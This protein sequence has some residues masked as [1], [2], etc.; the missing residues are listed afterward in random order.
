M[1][2]WLGRTKRRRFLWG[3]FVVFALAWIGARLYLRS[4]RVA[5]LAAERLSAKFD[6]NVEIGAGDIGIIDDD[7]CLNSICVQDKESSL[8]T[9]E[10]LNVDVSALGLLFGAEPTRITLRGVHLH[11]RFDKEG[12]LLSPL[13]KVQG[14]GEPLPRVVIASGQVTLDQEGRAPFTLVGINGELS[15]D[16][17]DG[18]FT[19]TL[20]D[21]HWGTWQLTG[22]FS[23]AEPSGWLGLANATSEITPERLEKIPFIP[24]AIWQ[25][26][27]VEGTIPLEVKLYFAAKS[28]KVRYHVTFER[29]RLTLPARHKARPDL[30]L[31]SA[32]AV[33][34][35]DDD[36]LSL[37]GTV[38]DPYWGNWSVHA[39]LT[40]STG[41]ITLDVQTK[42]AL[43]TPA[44]LRALPWVPPTIWEQVRAEG[45]TPVHVMVSLVTREPGVRYRV[46]LQP[47]DT[48][49]WVK[50]IDLE[51]EHAG[52]RVEVEDGVVRLQGVRGKTAGGTLLTD[53]NFDFRGVGSKLK[54]DVD[55][56]GLSLR[57]LPAAWKLPSQIDGKLSGKADLQVSVRDGK[58]ETRGDGKGVIDDPRLAGFRIQTPIPLR[59]QAMGPRL[60][61]SSPSPLI[62]KLIQA[63]TPALSAAPRSIA[64]W[65]WLASGPQ[66]VG[67]ITD[68]LSDEAART[69]SGL[70]R[71][72][73][74]PKL[75]QG[76]TY[77]EANLSLDKVDLA[78]LIQRLGLDMPAPLTGTL[79]VNLLLAIPIDAPRDLKAYRLKGTAL[80]A[81]LAVDKMEFTEVQVAVDYA[82]GLLRLDDLAG[83]LAGSE[84]NGG[85]LT[86][87]A[88]LQLAPR[89]EMQADLNLKDID[90][91]AL[92]K[93]FPELPLRLAGK[94]TATALAR[95]DPR[96][97]NGKS[98]VSAEVSVKEGHL[99]IHGVPTSRLKG[100]L[101]FEGGES[102]YR[103]E[104]ES[105]GGR[106]E[107]DAKLPGDT[108]EV[109]IGTAN[110]A[111]ATAEA[112]GLF[113]FERVRL[114]QVW[115]ILGQP[116]RLRSLEGVASLELPLRFAANGQP[117]GVGKFRILD[118]R[119]AD[120][121]L[122]D[123][124][125]GEIRLTPDAV[126][127][128]DV[129]ADLAGGLLRLQVLY[130]HH[131]PLRSNFNLSLTRAEASKLLLAIP[132]LGDLI[133]GAV[134]IRIRGTLGAEWRGGGALAMSRGKVLNVEITDWRVPFEFS[135]APGRGFGELTIRDSGAH[136][137]GGRA[138]LRTQVNW[139]G[140]GL[141]IDGT[142]T[143]I[144][145]GMRSLVGLV[146]DV[147]SYAQGRVNGRID[148]GGSNVR[149]MTDLMA[150]LQLSLQQAQAAQLPILRQLSPYLTR[151]PTGASF[152][153]GELQ[154]RF[155]NG[156]M[157]LQRLTLVGQLVQLII[158]GT[159]GRQ[160]RLD[161]D[162][163]ARTG[164]LGPDPLYLRLL[165]LKLPPVGPIPVSLLIQASGYL[166]NRLVRL[167]VN[168][169]TKNPVV[170]VEPFKVLTEDAAQFF[171]IR[172]LI[173]AP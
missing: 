65:D 113:R 60:R 160:G 126:I 107:L 162:V 21:P 168:G 40:S 24:P 137:G 149:S 85:S 151:G 150:Q 35:G 43:V 130:N 144:E 97:E 55:V 166:S 56:H 23:P 18:Q 86:G 61:F 161:L 57:K 70:V 171:L 143:L 59:L 116:D 147:S 92:A 111:K 75:G 62:Q 87:T 165:Q 12:R 101:E 84:E 152:Q 63:A 123:T 36:G 90:I 122:A 136:I 73:R 26:V 159:I 128:R 110:A 74:K 83:H 1:M 77:L 121:E 164:T 11:L 108:G 96:G 138:L 134:D 133:Q 14:E 117:T 29:A 41:A 82:N 5:R 6:V 142:V 44:K 131:D 106:F 31:A 9:I 49:V 8:L 163:T 98:V 105:L 145:A 172:A 64:P 112:T 37:N 154:G 39:G 7:S 33:I 66:M 58:V 88:R 45:R 13:P 129:S 95:F 3:I 146:G 69:I 104:G 109:P 51:A 153:S 124:V 141:R 119:W 20:S 148:F 127:L 28:P 32:R 157:R 34:D 16:G 169:T 135:L 115:P 103:L 54:F 118:M 167:R 79:S 99:R 30:R 38:A 50:A 46:E 4:G 15:P 47:R 170:Q 17:E 80:L 155:A 25:Q 72:S 10:E 94:V 19:G 71:L 158:T 78:L 53:G 93:A 67:E 68:H 89:G 140:A 2:K 52:G 102:H 22:G 27:R 91:D 42:D 173:P 81:H 76:P 125:V 48:K 100:S 120:S 139:G 132:G 114:R 156:V